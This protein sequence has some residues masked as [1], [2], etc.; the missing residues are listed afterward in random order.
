[1]FYLVGFFGFTRFR[2]TGLARYLAFACAGFLGSLMSKEIAVTFPAMLVAYDLFRRSAAVSTPPRTEGDSRNGCGKELLPYLPIAVLFAAYLLVRAAIFDSVLRE[3]QWVFSVREATTS[4]AGLRAQFGRLGTEFA[5]LQEFNAGQF[6]IEL[7]PVAVAITLGAVAAWAAR[8]VRTG[9]RETGAIL[10]TLYFGGV[11]YLI[12]S[13][14]LLITYHSPRH[15]YLPAAGPCIALACL[16]ASGWSSGNRRWG[17]V[18][19]TRTVAAI[20][21]LAIFGILLWKQNARWVRAGEMSAKLARDFPAVLE[22][23]PNEALVVAWAPSDFAKAYVWAWVMPFALQPPFVSRDLYSESRLLEFPD[24][25]CC[26]LEQWW[27]RKRPILIAVLSG[28][29]EA[30]AQ[31]HRLAWDE[32]SSTVI[33]LK[34]SLPRKQLRELVEEI[35]GGPLEDAHMISY[36][37][38]IK[39][40]SAFIDLTAQGQ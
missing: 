16:A 27:E 6:L 25:Y 11:W 3:G 12:A 2:A 9:R 20:A 18:R 14:P 31:V 15:L 35:L 34:V 40:M 33:R 32:R 29:P 5:R 1:M 19:L 22:E 37:T 23:T 28:D 21:L 36:D 24:M 30:Q 8:A 17:R 7:P 4:A 26:P 13:L 10:W 39:L 38:A